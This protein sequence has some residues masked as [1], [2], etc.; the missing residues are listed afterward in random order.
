MECWLKFVFSPV[1]LA[2]VSHTWELIEL[3]FGT[4]QNIYVTYVSL[5]Y[6]LYEQCMTSCKS[7]KSDGILFRM[8]ICP[9]FS[10]GKRK[11]N[12]GSARL[13]TGC[14]RMNNGATFG[15]RAF[16]RRLIN[17]RVERELSQRCNCVIGSKFLSESGIS[18][19]NNICSGTWSY[20]E[21]FY[22]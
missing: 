7:R 5:F 12:L 11:M 19:L 16:I 18:G 22:W 3:E 13:Q 8:G 4:P 6:L 14:R 2:L 20:A 9:N 10:R 21:W 17:F 15:K 1:L